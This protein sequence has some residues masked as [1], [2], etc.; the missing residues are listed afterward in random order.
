M[1]SPDPYR[2]DW[3]IGH[4]DRGPLADDQVR[5]PRPEKISAHADEGPRLEDEPRRDRPASR[6]QADAGELAGDSGG[7]LSHPGSNGRTRPRA[8]L[9][10]FGVRQPIPA[11]PIPLLAKDPEPSLDLGAVLHAP[12]ERARFDLVL[13]YSKS[14]TPP[15]GEEDATWAREIISGARPTRRAP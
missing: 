12:Y 14:P 8:E 3:Q 13:N 5:R 1:V 11:I 7:R 15:L 4:R 9:Y 6:W 10:V 2:R